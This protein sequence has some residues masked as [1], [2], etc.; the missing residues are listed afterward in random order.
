MAIYWIFEVLPI[1][2]TALL[3][4]L[5]YPLFGLMKA[6]EISLYYFS[7]INVLF[8]CGLM[9]A[10]AIESWNLHKRIA[11]KV[12]LCIGAKPER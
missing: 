4:I 8:L 11:L 2:A 9:I 5:L 7:D 12:I 6:S 1:A 3:P 10:V